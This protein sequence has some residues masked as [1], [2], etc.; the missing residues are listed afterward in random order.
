MDPRSQSL[1]Q[2]AAHVAGENA[3]VAALLNLDSPVGL[4]N[5]LDFAIASR[6]SAEVAE[7][8][9]ALSRFG[10]REDQARVL[11]ACDFLI[12]SGRSGEALAVWRAASRGGLISYPPEDAEAGHITNPEFRETPL[13]AGFDWRLP[14][15]TAGVEVARLTAAATLRIRLTGDQPERGELLGQYLAVHGPAEVVLSVSFRT[16]D[17]PRESGLRWMVFDA[18]SGAIVAKQANWL[19]APEGTNLQ[20]AEE[21]MRFHV[22]SETS[23]VKVVLMHERVPGTVR[24]QGDIALNR[25]QV[26]SVPTRT[27]PN[28][29][30]HHHQENDQ[31]QSINR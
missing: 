28:Q 30:H 23:A 26:S 20:W 9:I 24:A 21:R 5:F 12:Q 14:E 17:L 25:V 27:V 19:S 11:A 4:A 15:R 10:H 6:R 3:K 13:G 2:L 31:T 7:I 8:A 16:T 29:E 22:A 18:G 1:F